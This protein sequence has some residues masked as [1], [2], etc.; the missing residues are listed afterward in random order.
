MNRGS[1]IGS[2][3]KIMCFNSISIGL[4]CDLTWETQLID[5]SFHYIKHSGEDVPKEL[6][7]PIVLG[8]YCWIG[9]RSTISKG[10]VLPNYSIVASNSIVNK[11]FSS[12]GEQCFYAGMPAK[13]KATD[14]VREY[15][16]A[17]EADL[18]RKY[19]YTRRHL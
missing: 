15:D 14:I 2:G 16:T 11:D 6:T 18:D 1:F 19:N 13:C 10:T 8:D 12:F 7:A 3:C 4:H 9:N 17:K 5:T